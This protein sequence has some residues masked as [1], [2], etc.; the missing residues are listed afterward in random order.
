MTLEDRREEILNLSGKFTWNFD[1]T[2]FIETKIGT[3][4]WY[5]P[6][7]DGDNII[8]RYRESRAGI[9]GRDKGI[10]KIRD[11]CGEDIILVGE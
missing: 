7:Y 6:D 3:F 10:H 11:Y 1:Q 9:W 2:F 8:E 4:L 5:D